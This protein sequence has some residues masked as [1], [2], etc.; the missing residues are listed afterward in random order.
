MKY[1]QYEVWGREKESTEIVLLYIFASR[2]SA[3]MAV[4]LAERT[5]TTD[6]SIKVVHNGTPKV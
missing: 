2:E 5:G 3:E 6:L 1:P 4:E